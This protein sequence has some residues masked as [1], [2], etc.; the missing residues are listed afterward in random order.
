MVATWEGCDWAAVDVLVVVV[1]YRGGPALRRCLDGLAGQRAPSGLDGE[2]RRPDERPSHHVLVVDNGDVPATREVLLES[3]G[4][5]AVDV[6]T[7][8]RNLGFSA[9]ANI[10]LRA[11]SAAWEQGLWPRGLVVLVND[12]A[13]PRPDFLARLWRAHQEAG[14]SVGA[15]A[16]TMLLSQDQDR[17]N[18]TGTVVTR[19]GSARD[20][21]AGRLLAEVRPG[22]RVFGFCGGA[23]GLRPAALSAAGVF[24]DEWFLYYEDVDL[25]WRLRAAGLDVLHVPGA[26]AVHELAASSGTTSP[27]F[28]FHNDRN[29][30][31]TFTRHG[32]AGLVW[33][34]WLR[35]PF[36]VLAHALRATTRPLVPW[37][38]RAGRDA[39][40]RLPRTLA[41][42]RRLWSGREDRR[43][44]VATRWLGR[45][46]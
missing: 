43:R 3:S 22:E 19:L 8:G 31:T 35:F 9:G 21:D 44:A 15:F 28:R 46:R 26:V 4:D 36:A 13:V 39:F 11:A 24:E 12:D 42:R 45:D 16:A 7:P 37:R 29:W 27:V 40:V 25:S 23:A 6:V 5:P 30:L 2:A 20:R 14:P 10:G 33:R 34:R 32:P 1:T 38:L 41:E 17:V 18:S